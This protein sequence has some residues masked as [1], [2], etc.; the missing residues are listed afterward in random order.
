MRYNKKD[1]VNALK[2][3]G[4][5]QGDILFSHSNLGF[6]GLP[7]GGLNEENIFSIFYDAIFDV[8]GDDGLLVVPTFTY[9]FNSLNNK[10]V[11]DYENS[12]SKMGFFPEMIRKREDSIRT[13]DPL[14]SCSLNGN[15]EKL[16]S[17]NIISTECFGEGSI[18]ELLLKN[19]AKLCNFNLDVGFSTF[20]HY[21]EKVC[22]VPYRKNIKFSGTSIMRD[23]TISH[24][25]DY[26]CRENVSIYE[27]ETQEYS[28]F[29]KNRKKANYS[30]VA[31]GEIV[32]MNIKDS[33]DIFKEMYDDN[34]YF[35]TKEKKKRDD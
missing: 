19:N 25:V 15:T 5:K 30:I 26:F 16:F 10:G 22:N 23:K 35:F 7:E 34:P 33:L 24:T 14:F 9:S 32:T 8:I 4:V 1:I 11:F 6:F 27:A 28:D 20:L 13:F 21:C 29:V 12:E 3:V 31:R 17:Q 18:W 2:D